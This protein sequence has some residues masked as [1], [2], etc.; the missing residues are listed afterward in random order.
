MQRQCGWC[1]TTTR[2]EER[3]HCPSCGGPLPALP[4]AVLV[5]RGKE[6]AALVPP[7]PPLAPREFP[8][9]YARRVRYWNNVPVIIGMI[10]TLAFF[11]TGIFP[12]IGIPMWV[13]GMR[14]ANRKLRALAEG[15]AAEGT[16]M[17]VRADTSVTKNGQHPWRLDYVFETPRGTFEG[18]AQ[19]WHPSAA[20]RETGEIV[21]VVY[22]PGEEETVNAL[23]PPIR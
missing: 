23:W 22:V 2:D 8:A 16:I 1:G 19:A 13:F 7:P 18:T 10:F 12:L 15:E 20:R 17:A 3:T 14:R 9:K 4:R 21:Q 6:G 5:E 11:W